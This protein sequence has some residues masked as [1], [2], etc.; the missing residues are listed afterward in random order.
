[1]GRRAE[2]AAHHRLQL[3]PPAAGEEGEEGE[4]EGRRGGEGSHQSS[5][6]LYIHVGQAGASQ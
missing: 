2:L 1:M 3:N 6:A 4:G 5:L